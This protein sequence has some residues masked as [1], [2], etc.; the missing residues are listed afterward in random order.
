MANNGILTTEH[1]TR[2]GSSL[3]PLWFFN[4]NVQWLPRGI[5]APGIEYFVSDIYF[6]TV[7]RVFN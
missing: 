4:F 5:S 1:T 6:S 7:N 3:C 2:S